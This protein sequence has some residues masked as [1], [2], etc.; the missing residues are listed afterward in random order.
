MASFSEKEKSLVHIVCA[1]I[2]I[3]CAFGHILS[4]QPTEMVTFVLDKVLQKNKR[5][6][7]LSFGDAINNRLNRWMLVDAENKYRL[8]Y[9]PSVFLTHMVVSLNRPFY[10]E[11]HGN[12]DTETVCRAGYEATLD[13]QGEL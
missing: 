5:C 10:R 7:S 6:S 2:K 13:G 4:I 11:L 1:C 3:H 8:R 12:L 9:T